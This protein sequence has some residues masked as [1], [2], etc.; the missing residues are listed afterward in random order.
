[1]KP[2]T[3]PPPPTPTKSQPPSQSLQSSSSTAPPA[4]KR[5]PST[6]SIP[7]KPLTKLIAAKVNTGLNIVGGSAVGGGGVSR[8]PTFNRAVSNKS[9]PATAP[10]NDKTNV[11]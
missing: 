11:H 2:V 4:V 3:L 6:Q 8:I 5:Q 1:K 10:L 7:S 9:R